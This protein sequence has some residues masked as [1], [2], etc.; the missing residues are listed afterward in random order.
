MISAV[1]ASLPGCT[2]Q[3]RQLAQVFDHAYFMNELL[4]NLYVCVLIA[5][6]KCKLLKLVIH[7]V[8][9]FIISHCIENP[10]YRTR[11][12]R[13]NTGKK[14]YLFTPQLK[15]TKYTCIAVTLNI[16]L[17]LFVILSAGTNIL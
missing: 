6:V 17:I 16:N 1:I 9:A 12:G 11:V 4:F 5:I 8:Y 2:T 15:C 14:Q 3:I 13:K 10:F 7:N